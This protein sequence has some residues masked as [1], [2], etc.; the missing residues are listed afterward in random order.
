MDKGATMRLRLVQ[1]TVEVLNECGYGG[2]T[3]VEVVRRA[4]VSR[5]ALLHHFPTRADLLL[6]TAAYILTAQEEF[7][8]EKLRDVERGSARF[9]S[10][11][12]AMWDTMQQPES[13]ALTE[14]MLGSRGDDE[15]RDGFAELMQR[16]ASQLASGAGEVA[17]DIGFSDSRLVRA[18][19]KLHVAAMRGL[20]I[21]RHYYKGGDTETDAAFELLVWY[22]QALMRRL[23]DPSWEKRILLNLERPLQAPTTPLQKRTKKQNNQP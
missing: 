20:M 5:G 16:S 10:I 4:G 8:R 21:D 22:K 9:L 13:A 1:A 14:L 2:T 15:V 11:T 6:A 19:T 3:T 12:D 18:M 23:A 7:R 17:E